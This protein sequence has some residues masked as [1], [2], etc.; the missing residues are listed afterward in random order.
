MRVLRIPAITLFLL[1]ACLCK[2][3]AQVDISR[4]SLIYYHVLNKID[5]FA[6]YLE[7]ISDKSAD[8]SDVSLNI[9]LA[10][11]LFV[12][13]AIIEVSNVNNP[14]D[15]EEYTP[16]EYFEHLKMLDYEEVKLEVVSISL[17]YM[18]KK[19]DG[20]YTFRGQ[21]VQDFNGSSRVGLTY[22]DRTTK[23]IYITGD[24]IDDNYEFKFL[25]IKVIETI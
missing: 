21:Y 5:E 12:D 10:K 16:L 7:V 3:V 13:G 24:E 6:G 22:T 19:K 20:S 15:I 9:E 4:D 2:L 23:E 8:D 14:E 18:L 17:D 11:A 25:G 1:T